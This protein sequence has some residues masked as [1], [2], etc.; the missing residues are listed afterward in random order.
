MANKLGVIADC[1]RTT[2]VSDYRPRRLRRGRTGRA[3]TIRVGEWSA[4]KHQADVGLG[5]NRFAGELHRYRIQAKAE[6]ISVDATLTGDVP[7]WRPSTVY[8][9]F[10]AGRS[11]EFA[12]LPAVPQGA[13]TVTYSVGDEQR[14]TTG[15]G[16]H[17]HNWG[18]V[19]LM[20]VVHDWYWARGQAGPYS[21]YNQKLWM[22]D[23]VKGATYPPS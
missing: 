7:P 1:P 22:H 13:V 16:Y 23:L 5:E 17:N 2:S 10:G 4:A 21:S 19:G 3:P 6:E 20:K 8:I 18:N 15:V 11:L 9:R 14:E 12:C